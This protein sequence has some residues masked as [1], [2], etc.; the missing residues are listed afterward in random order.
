[1]KEFPT[2]L[3]VNNKENFTYLNYSRIKCY[4]RKSIYEHIISHDENSYFDLEK[5]GSIHI[6]DLK[7]KDLLYTLSISIQEELSKLGWKCK[8][9]FGG[10]ALFIFS[11]IDPPPGC[12]DDGL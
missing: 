7:H 6:T 2:K 11:S 12:W 9:S 10:T 5:F 4:L 1:M 3:N 8:T